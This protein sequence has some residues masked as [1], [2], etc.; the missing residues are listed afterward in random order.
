[1]RILRIL[2][3]SFLIAIPLHAEPLKPV[4]LVY[5]LTGEA[6]TTGRPLRLYDRLPAGATLKVGTK[7]RLALAFVNGLRYE[8]GEGSSVTIGARDLTSRQGAVRPL[9]SAPPL[10]LLSPISAEDHPGP[11]AGAVRIRGEEIENLSPREG[12]VTLANATMFHFQAAKGA[13]RYA[14]EIENA[15]GKVIFHAVTELT[16]VSVPAGT[17][18]AGS[19]YHWTVKTLDK[20]GP[21]VR[22]EADFS[23]LSRKAAEAR[24]ELRKAAEASGDDN[25]KALLAAVDHDLDL[26]NENPPKAAGAVIESVAPSSPGEA[27]GLRPGDVILSWSCPASPP[28]FPQPSQGTVR[29][30]YDLLPLDIEEAPRRG[31]TLRGKR[32][33]SDLTWTLT[34]TEWGIEVRPVLPN[35]LLAFYTEGRANV[36]AGNFAAAERSWRSA[37]ESAR[38]NGNGRLAAWFLDRLASAFAKGGK[39]PETD[40]LYGEA[41]ALLEREPDLPAAAHLLRQWGDIFQRRAS[42]DASVDRFQKALALDRRTAPKSLAEARTLNMLG[43]TAMKSGDYPAAEDSLRQSLAL[44]EELA[45][46][47]AVIAASLN[48]LGVLA[49]WRGDLTA[50]EEY[51]TRGD[52]LL[53]RLAPESSDHARIFQNL[54]NV[55]NDRGD[56]ERAERFHRRALAIFEKTDPGG[57]GVADCLHNLATLT[58]YRGDLAATENLLRRSLALQ[59]REAPDELGVASALINLG[60]VAER[61]GDLDEAEGHY[62]RALEIQVKLAPDETLASSSLA[63]LGSIAMVRGD[64]DTARSYLNRSLKIKERL[65]RDNVTVVSELQQLGYVEMNSGDLAKAE[66]LLQRALTILEKQAPRSVNTS[67]VLRNLGELEA[68]RGRLTEAIALHRRALDLQRTLA[69]ES[70]AE[71]EVLHLLGRAEQRAGRFKEGTQDLCHAIDVLDRQRA[72]LGGT[73]EEQASFEATLGDYYYYCLDGLIQTGRPTEAFH[74]LER[75]RA[76]SF[77]ALLAE[78]DINFSDLSPELA[79]ERRHVDAEY[80]RVQSDLT[81]LSTGQDDADIE[82]LTGELRNLRARQEEIRAR[83]RR[84]SP[85]SAALQDPELLDLAGARK[86]LDPGTVLLEYAVGPERTWLFAVQPAS[87]SRPGLSVFPIAAGSKALREE[88]ESFRRLLKRPS[89]DRKALQEQARHLYNLLVRPAEGQISKAQRILVSPDGPLHILPFAALIR[90]DGYLVESKPVHSALSATVYAELTRSRPTRREAGEERLA[91]F[92]APSYPITGPTTE[93]AAPAD[94]EV[95]EAVQ[96]GLTLKPLPF[97]RQEVEA[98]TALYSQSHAYL[99][100]EATEEKAK[101]IGPESRLVHFACHGLLDERFPLNSSLALTLPKEQKEGQDNGLLQA[102]EIFEHVRL[103][104]DLVTLSACDTALGREMGG[105]GLVGL[106]RAFQYAGARSV[107]ASV[108]GIADASTARFMQR[109]YGYLHSGKTKDEALRAA[110]IDQIREKSG[111]SHPFYWAAFQLTGDWR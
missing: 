23:T 19:R 40:A 61:R 72:R 24:E 106:T 97:S 93:L 101:S 79:A 38:N 44:R 1:M 13:G 10:P 63:S 58:F 100:Q 33:N 32:E 41:L 36:E 88:I 34:N 56:M 25:L 91:A 94:P 64:L 31:V 45:P 28:N 81:H 39:W 77:L 18:A 46:G 68:R 96:R 107:L 16:N 8:L 71:A 87:V 76:R 82:R 108:W 35:D 43:V 42:W 60:N 105:E 4:A 20:P 67:I 9:T 52:E 59:E 7:S 104:A 90:G 11:H 15:R 47:N 110:Q 102:W 57:K 6:K 85:R 70:T 48:K 53:Q 83:I 73:Q 62:R 21:V 66:T 27:A 92:G 103:D 86:V 78:R 69:P 65:A 5:S 74:T 37:A 12:A 98:I 84:E 111:S 95:Q 109:F 22:G 2:G 29:S 51:L 3:L 26:T 75:G 89:S 14:V 55:S 30:P 50:A 80:D 54:G 49:R 17:L 99:G